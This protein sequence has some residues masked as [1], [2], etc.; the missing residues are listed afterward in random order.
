MYS[1]KYVDINHHVVVPWRLWGEWQCEQLTYLTG[2][3]LKC[4]LGFLQIPSCTTGSPGGNDRVNTGLSVSKVMSLVASDSCSTNGHRWP[5][6]VILGQ[7][8]QDNALNII[9]HTP[10]HTRTPRFYRHV[11]KWWR[12]REDVDEMFKGSWSLHMSHAA[13]G[14]LVYWCLPAPA[15]PGWSFKRRYPAMPGGHAGLGPMAEP[16]Q[17]RDGSMPGGKTHGCRAL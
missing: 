8:K 4:M 5:R 17:G 16:S 15:A 6:I 9:H 14:L 2:K 12:F 11:S 3:Y 13:F 7:G 1:L 10:S